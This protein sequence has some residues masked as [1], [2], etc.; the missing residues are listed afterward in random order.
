MSQTAGVARLG[1]IV[2]LA[3]LSLDQ[4]SKNL[5]LYGYG[6][7][8]KL[9]GDGYVITPFFNIIMAWNPGVSY[10]LFPMHSWWG[11]ALLTAFALAVVVGLAIWLHRTASRLLALGLGMVIGGAVGNAIDRGLYGAVAD[12]FDFHAWGYH[13]YVFNIADVGI[14]CGVGVLILDSLIETGRNSKQSSQDA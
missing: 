14:V 1:W 10:G 8:D 5:L 7:K 6:F 4:A 9:Q 11:K 3:V 12:F 2:A 13:W